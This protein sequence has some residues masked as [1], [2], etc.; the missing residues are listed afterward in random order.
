MR[1]VE[2]L[3]GA[4]ASLVTSIEKP[5]ALECHM[6]ASMHADGTSFH[7]RHKSDPAGT[8]DL[9]SRERTGG[10]PHKGEV[11]LGGPELLNDFVDQR[12]WRKHVH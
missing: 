1:L 11:G 2:G 7:P 8:E 6:R 5:A 3:L 12:E 10:G 4:A 9:D